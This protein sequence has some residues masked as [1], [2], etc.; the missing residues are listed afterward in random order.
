MAVKIGY[1]AGHGMGTAGKRVDIKLDPKQTR[2]WFLNNRIANFIEAGLKDYTGYEF[3]RA[4]DRTGATD[5]SLA[6]RVTKLNNWGADVVISV[7]HNAGANLTNAGGITV[8]IAKA[9]SAKSKEYQKAIY[10]SLVKHT[11]LKGNRASPLSTDNFYM[12]TKTKAPA[13]LVEHGFMDSRIDAPIIL[14][15]SFAKKCAAAHIE[16]L[17]NTFGLKKKSNATAPTQPATGNLFRVRRAWEDAA[18]QKGAYRVLNNAI[19]EAKKHAGYKVFDSGGK[20][21]YPEA[22]VPKPSQPTEQK[23]AI[24][25]NPVATYK[26]MAKLL[27]SKNPNPKIKI[28]AEAFAKLFIDEGKAENIRGDIAFCQSMHETGW[29]KFG[30]LVLPEQNNYGGIGATNNS[31]VG[32]GAWFNSER[33]GVRAQIQ[34]LKAYANTLPLNNPNIDPRFHLVTRGVA[35]NW[36]DLNG[37]WAVPGPTYGQSILA[38]YEMLIKVVVEETPGNNAGDIKK[39]QDEINALK[40]ILDKVREKLKDLDTIVNS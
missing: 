38:M 24:E 10:N 12:V 15:E 9:S 4:D 28:S 13:V 26:Q 18:S 20:V 34:H 29:L 23:I 30:G 27:I 22:V 14:T 36:V 33:D 35:K 32:K 5:V 6:N 39:L 3:M 40:T 16:F 11:G 21:I 8:H 7:H 31:A 17:V 2:E 37:R 1:D 19:A 25:G